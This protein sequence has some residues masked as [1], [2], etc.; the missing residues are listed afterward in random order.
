MG[1]FSYALTKILAGAFFDALPYHA[2]RGH[3][4]RVAHLAVL[5]FESMGKAL[6]R[7]PMHPEIP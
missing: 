1:R 5:P 7:P 2:V 3:M 6:V 4:G